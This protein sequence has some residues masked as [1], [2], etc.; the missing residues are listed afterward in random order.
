MPDPL[1]T[2]MKTPFFAL[3]LLTAGFR[4]AAQPAAPLTARLDKVSLT[5]ALDA[6]GQPTYAVHYA[7]RPVITPSRLGIALA[8]GA[9][10]DGALQVTGT[11]VKESDTTWQPVW[12]EVKDIRNH[13]QQ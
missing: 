13:Y 11:D 6:K 12:G 10:F 9:G 7:Q 2:L 3:L 1:P 8:D 5:F 4:T